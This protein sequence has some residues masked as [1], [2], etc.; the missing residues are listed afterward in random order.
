M[1]KLKEKILLMML[2]TSILLKKD[3]TDAKEITCIC[4][5]MDKFSIEYFISNSYYND[6]S[7]LEEYINLYLL[8]L[9]NPTKDT[10]IK[11]SHVKNN[12]C[13]YIIVRS[14]EEK[15]N[16]S[17]LD[18]Y[19][20]LKTLFISGNV[21]FNNHKVSTLKE[22]TLSTGKN[23]DLSLFPNIEK[24]TIY[25][26]C[27]EDSLYDSVNNLKNIDTL[28][29]TITGLSNIDIKR[30][31]VNN[32]II[33]GNLYDVAINISCEDIN[34]LRSKGINITYSDEDKLKSI[35]DYLNNVL[36]SLD[37]NN[38]ND[39][40]II[41][42]VLLYVINHLD[43][44]GDMNIDYYYKE[45]LLYGAINNDKHICGNYA[46]FMQAL[47]KRINKESYIISSEDYTHAFNMV[48]IDNKYYFVDPTW[49]DY[50]DIVD[51]LLNKED[52]ESL[53]KWYRFDINNLSS[54]EGFEKDSHIPLYLPIDYPLFKKD[55]IL[56]SNKYV[57][58]ITYPIFLYLIYLYNKR[59]KYVLKRELI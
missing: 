20:S 2:I 37:L 43:Y 11:L 41:D 54:L 39:N 40:E 45:G 59:N 35:D 55:I 58:Y 18:N 50:D 28:N 25:N 4:N 46:S 24:L 31:N 27:G 1:K 13:K 30:F 12:S 10:M 32:I 42:K 44:S 47:L 52:I 36:L 57:I 16:L 3:A 29:I 15:T 53:S 5:T 8:V 34:F 9:D 21:S 19:P 26:P 22:L 51:A 56:G 48:K 6:L 38:L 14:E 33:K 17:F 23:I 7:F 49:L